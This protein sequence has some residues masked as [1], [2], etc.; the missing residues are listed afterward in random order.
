ME[1]SARG[2]ISGGAQELHYP[3]EWKTRRAKIR[4]LVESPAS[5]IAGNTFRNNKNKKK[6]RSFTEGKSNGNL[7]VMFITQRLE[8]GCGSGNE[9]PLVSDDKDLQ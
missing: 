7:W 9:S 8:W 4:M 2:D 5:F 6:S 3:G 1:H